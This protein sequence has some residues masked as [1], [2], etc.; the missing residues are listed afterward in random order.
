MPPID[1]LL[2]LALP[3]SG[4]S[5]IRRYLDHLDPA[6]RL[7]DL[8][9]GRIVELDDYPYV[10]LMILIDLAL[11]E[12]EVAPVFFEAPGGRFRDGRDWG[13]LARLLAEDYAALGSESR[14]PPKPLHHFLS[15]FDRA[16]ARVGAPPITPKLESKVLDR[17]ASQLDAECEEVDGLAAGAAAAYGDDATVIVEFARGGPEGSSMPLPAPCGYVYTLPHLGPEMLD[18]AAILYVWATPEESRRRN[19]ERGRPGGEKNATVLHHSTPE[20]VMR[21]DY[22]VDDL[23]W[24]IEQG[25]GAVEVATNGAT[26]RVPAATLDNRVDRTSF[27]RSEPTSWDPQAVASL[28]GH[29][30]SAMRRLR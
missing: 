15:R 22:G 20:I 19:R 30:A 5:E 14:T 11:V 8:G 12:Q 7:E 13:T 4:K 28:H 23:P 2:L 18:R 10:R 27:L 17:L 24:L 16:R 6:A 3:A 26:I 9:I 1:T 21:L 25:G 29:L